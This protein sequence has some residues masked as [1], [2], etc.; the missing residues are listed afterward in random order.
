MHVEDEFIVSTQYLSVGDN[1]LLDGA[2]SHAQ[3]MWLLV[4][5][6]PTFPIA[7]LCFGAIMLNETWRRRV[8]RIEASLVSKG[9]DERAQLV[10]VRGSCQPILSSFVSSTLQ[11][12]ITLR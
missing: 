3:E 5:E 12:K 4:S 10:L 8:P 7:G 6:L 2:V 11:M 1:M 9:K